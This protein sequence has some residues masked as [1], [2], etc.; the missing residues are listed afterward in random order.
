[1]LVYYLCY[2]LTAVSHSAARGAKARQMTLQQSRATVE[3][4]LTAELSDAGKCFR[5][6]AFIGSHANDID[7]FVVLAAAGR[8][9]VDKFLTLIIRV[10]AVQN[11]LKGEGVFLSVFPTFRLEVFDRALAHMNL[12]AEEGAVVQLHLL[13]YPSYDDFVQW[14]DPMI[15][16]TICRRARVVV[17]DAKELARIAEQVAIPPLQ[18]RISYLVSLLLEN[19]RFLGCS[20]VGDDVLLEEALHKSLYVARYAAFNY[21]LEEGC[22]PRE[23]LTWDQI[24]GRR[25]RIKD[26][27]LSELLEQAYVWRTRATDVG[28][29]QLRKFDEQLLRVLE[30]WSLHTER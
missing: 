11:R 30:K 1:M 13:V 16:A 24:Q 17:G 27:L 10:K 4:A 9:F 20:L 18:R 28:V 14:E 29:E 25:E 6:V 5:T 19:L 3:K 23:V 8:D 15:V 12:R 26:N 22:R 21:L 7:L 2:L